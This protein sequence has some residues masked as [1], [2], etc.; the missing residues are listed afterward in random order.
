MKSIQK[1]K[2]TLLGCEQNTAC[3]IWEKY[4]LAKAWK[5]YLEMDVHERWQLEGI[6]NSLE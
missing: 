2:E 6:E 5:I 1:K 4:Q 3:D